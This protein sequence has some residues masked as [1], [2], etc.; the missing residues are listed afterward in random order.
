MNRVAIPVLSL[1]YPN[2]SCM[3]S[4]SEWGMV[5]CTCNLNPNLF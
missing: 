2:L 5:V 1:V 3:D 4:L